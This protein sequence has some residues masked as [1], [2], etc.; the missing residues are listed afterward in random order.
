[1]LSYLLLFINGFVLFK[2]KYHIF[3]AVTLHRMI[4]YLFHQNNKT[5]MRAIE[6]TLN[7]KTNILKSTQKYVRFQSE[8]ENSSMIFNLKHSYHSIKRSCQR[9]I[10][11]E[12]IAI[13]TEFGICYFGQGLNYYVLGKK[14]VPFQLRKKS[15]NYENTIV[16]ISS[17]TSEIVTCYRNNNPHQWIKNKRKDLVL[18]QTA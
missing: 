7:I 2:M 4:R 14:D 8:N 3:C 9:G 1:M 13:T 5:T 10:S 12:Q 16:I 6:K 11:S 18:K 15:S 17:N